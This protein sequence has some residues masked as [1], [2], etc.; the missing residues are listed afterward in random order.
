MRTEK[1]N[2]LKHKILNF[3]YITIT[4]TVDG[5]NS[6]VKSKRLDF[7]KFKKCKNSITCS[8]TRDTLKFKNS[9]K[10][11]RKESIAI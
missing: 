2:K 5:L 9:T 4:I 10:S 3:K 1:W 11:K 8:F 7:R 6:P